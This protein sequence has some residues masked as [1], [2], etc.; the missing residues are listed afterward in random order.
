MA[1]QITFTALATVMFIVGATARNLPPPLCEDLKNEL[2]KRNAQ[3]F[4]VGEQEPN[5]FLEEH[6]C[7]NPSGEKSYFACKAGY[8]AV[9]KNVADLPI[10]NDLDTIFDINQLRLL[11]GSEDKDSVLDCQPS[12]AGGVQ[13]EISISTSANTLP[14]C[15]ALR[16]ELRQRSVQLFTQGEQETNPLLE[17][18][19][20]VSQLE[21]VVSYFGCK[22]GY[23]AVVKNIDDLQILNDLDIVFNIKQL[24]L[25]PQNEDD[26]SILDCQPQEAEDDKTSFTAASVDAKVSDKEPEEEEAAQTKVAPSAQA[27]T[28]PPLCSDVSGG[29]YLRQFRRESRPRVCEH[30]CRFPV[31]V[32]GQRAGFRTRRYYTC[33]EG[34]AE[35]IGTAFY[36]SYTCPQ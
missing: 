10:I 13:N 23:E 19:K 34:E 12:E 16:S 27:S 3:M 2:R 6:K 8:K 31:S 15:D 4:V 25:L 11:R 14:Q 32:Y 30:K 26:D 9:I 28:T 18:H 35:P 17:E 36:I 20:C 1:L 29:L 24:R 22:P 5:P 21:G 7:V 33:C